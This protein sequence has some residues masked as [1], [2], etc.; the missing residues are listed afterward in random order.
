MT[1]WETYLNDNQGRYLEEL[2][3]FLRIPSISSLSEH[4]PDV[5]RAA[6]WLVARLTKA[7]LE[8]VAVLPTGGHPVV[9][10]QWLKAPGKPTVL[11]YGHFDVQPVDPL[12]LWTDPPFEPVVLEDRIYARGA[13]DDKGNLLPPIL[14]IEAL[15][16]TTGELPV[17]VKFLLEGQEEIGSPDLPAFV[18]RHKARLACDLVLSADGGQW[19]E[20]QPGLNMGLRGLC[21]L[22]LDV[23]GPAAD[24][25]SGTYGGTFLNPI[26]GLIQLLKTLHDTDGRVRVDGFYDRV[27]ARSPQERAHIARV[28]YDEGAYKQKLGLAALH[29]EAGYTTHERKWI[30]PTLEFNGI[31]G[32]FQQEGIKTVIPSEAHCKISCRLVPD[33]SPD[34]IRALVRDYL[35]RQDLPGLQVKVDYI[36]SKADPYLVPADHPGNRAAAKVLQQLYG[37]DPLAVYMGGTIPVCGILKSALGAYT[38]NFAFALDDENVHSPNEFFR[39]ANFRRGQKAYGLILEELA[40]MDLGANSA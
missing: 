6:E 37:R 16:Q 39:L 11:I 19:T 27:Q 5:E 34:E 36:P 8:E 18:D 31:W 3:D 15:L 26:Q 28:P 32:G 9:Y 1:H 25:H 20:T 30:R 21:A 23:R 38:I 4:L 14:A 40:G 10:G 17:N 22:Q 7:G 12:E 13:S 24:V 2:K 29:G 33:Q 35:L